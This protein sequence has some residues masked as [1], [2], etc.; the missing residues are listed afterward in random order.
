[1]FEQLCFAFPLNITA[2]IA[3]VTIIR[4]VFRDAELSGIDVS[5]FETNKG[6]IKGSV[7]LR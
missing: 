1:M 6:K 7:Q 2:M 4:D 5:A 3:T